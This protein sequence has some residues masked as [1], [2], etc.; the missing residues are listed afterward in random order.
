MP[1]PDTR[2]IARRDENALSARI[3][4]D[5]GRRKRIAALLQ[6]HAVAGTRY[7]EVQ[8]KSVNV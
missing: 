8:M 3:H 1:I 6:R 4:L 7:P 5:D 2:S